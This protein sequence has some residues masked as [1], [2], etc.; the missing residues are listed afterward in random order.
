VIEGEISPFREAVVRLV[1]RGADDRE[2]EVAVVVDTGFTE[3][4]TLPPILVEELGLPRVDTSELELADGRIVVFPVHR[5]VVLWE[6]GERRVSVHVS[7][8][9]PLMGMTML[10][11][12]NL[13]LDVVD[14]GHV[15]IEKLA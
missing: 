6:G 13:N 3:S 4:L 7:E 12:C 1:L 2:R 5:A 9:G 11:G 15:R 10:Y 8:G 14:G